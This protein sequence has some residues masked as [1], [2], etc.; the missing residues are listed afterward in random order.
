MCMFY[1][2]IV[3]T[4]T[5]RDQPLRLILNLLFYHF[6]HSE[7]TY[8]SQCKKLQDVIAACNQLIANALN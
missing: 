6:N 5:K 1:I 8:I 7:S 2:S 4:Y 3:R